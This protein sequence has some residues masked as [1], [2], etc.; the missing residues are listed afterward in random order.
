MLRKEKRMIFHRSQCQD[1]TGLFCATE[2]YWGWPRAPWLPTHHWPRMFDVDSTI[3]AQ[4]KERVQISGLGKEVFS[5]D[6]SPKESP[7]SV[8][9]P[10][11][12]WSQGEGNVWVPC[13]LTFRCP[14]FIKGPDRPACMDSVC[15]LSAVGNYGM[16]PSWELSTEKDDGLTAGLSSIGDTQCCIGE[17]YSSVV[18]SPVQ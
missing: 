4:Y 1:T 6:Q 7:G 18:F 11:L 12:S 13:L 3:L 15:F 8:N 10:A 9:F 5:I 16:S 17:I 14:L 2:N